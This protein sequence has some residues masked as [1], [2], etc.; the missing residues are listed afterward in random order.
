M[1][2]I[3]I[4]SFVIINCIFLL[5]F[6]FYSSIKSFKFFVRSK[7]AIME[8]WFNYMC[9]KIEEFLIKEND[10]PDS[11]KLIKYE[12]RRYN[13]RDYEGML[14][15]IRQKVEAKKLTKFLK[16]STHKQKVELAIQINVNESASDYKMEKMKRKI[17][18]C[19]EL[20]KA[21]LY[22]NP[23]GVPI[24]LMYDSNYKKQYYG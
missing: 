6:I 22:Y 1:L 19:K 18:N 20:K 23:D 7:R 9:P 24:G 21:M 17:R 8:H 12:E 13:M 4:N 3:S 5:I 10:F 14:T 11:I 16:M 2:S 15:F